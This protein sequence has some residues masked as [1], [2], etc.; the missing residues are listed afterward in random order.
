MLP[1]L[2]L[3]G[4]YYLDKRNLK[5]GLNFLNFLEITANN[6]SSRENY[7]RK[8]FARV[9]EYA[10]K[11]EELKNPERVIQLITNLKITHKKEL[12][13]CLKKILI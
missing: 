11:K 12:I 2:I 13:S 6:L 9:R 7:S 3:R 8:E 4:L 1:A 10:A 5:P